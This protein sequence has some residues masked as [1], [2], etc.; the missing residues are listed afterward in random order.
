MVSERKNL[1]LAADDF[2]A[3]DIANQRILELAKL[4]KID[5]VAVIADGNFSA[6]EINDLK[7]S[8]LKI[9]VHLDLFGGKEEKDRGTIG[10]IIKFLGHFFSSEG[11]SQKVKAE[12]RRQIE[13]VRE[14][15][16]R[17]PDGLNSHQHIYYFPIYFRIAVKLAKDYQIPYLRFSHQIVSQKKS[18]VY[19][20][21]KFLQF[22]DKKVFKKSK[23]ET[24]DYL[25]SLDWLEEPIK[26]LDNYSRRGAVEL[27][28]HPEREEE[29]NI[30][31]NL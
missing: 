3:N 15:F 13:K 28:C 1:I 17:N 5:R 21:L 6:D 25:A 7:N 30:I 19:F 18:P 12:W 14:K 20:V 27:V 22:F 29:F 9:D 31:K 4:G 10:R 24:S 11:R 8:G 2:G 23:L 16:G 26:F